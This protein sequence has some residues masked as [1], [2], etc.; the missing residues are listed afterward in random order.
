MQSRSHTYDVGWVWLI[1]GLCIKE[2]EIRTS[3]TV[4]IMYKYEWSEYSINYTGLKYLVYDSFLLCR[5]YSLLVV[6]KAID[7]L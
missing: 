2:T 7:E 1:V 6:Y 4:I 5:S 3:E